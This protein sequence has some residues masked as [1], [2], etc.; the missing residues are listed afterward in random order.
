VVKFT[1]VDPEDVHLVRSG[2]RGRVSYPILKMFLESGMAVGKLDRAGMQQ[3]L[4]SL[5][6]SLGAYIRNHEL[7]LQMWTSQGEIYLARTDI[8]DDGKPDPKNNDI[9]KIRRQP[10]GVIDPTGV[11][12]YEGDDLDEDAEDRQQYVEAE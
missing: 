6:S 9:S 3:S 2:R 11:D 10:Q 12:E 4:M 8:G 7:P 5:N 1:E